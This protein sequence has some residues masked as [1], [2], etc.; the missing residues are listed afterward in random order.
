M[1]PLG[2]RRRMPEGHSLERAARRLRPLVGAR[3]DGGP[4]SG[5]VVSA[6][7]ARGKHLLVHTADGRCLHA[8]LGL[9]GGVRLRPPG[10]GRGGTCFAPPRAIS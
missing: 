5:A 3:V 7:E 9:H 2:Y 4:L 6:V 8:H 10:E 1:D